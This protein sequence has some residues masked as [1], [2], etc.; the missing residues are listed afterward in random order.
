MTRTPA[1]VAALAVVWLLA[2]VPA[3][4]GYRVV[5]ENGEETLVSAGRLK[6]IGRQGAAR[7]GQD[8]HA[9]VLD[10]NRARLWIADTTKRSYWEGSVEEFCA[11]MHQAMTAAFGRLGDQMQQQMAEL[12]QQIAE[13]P[14]DE[15]AQTRQMRTMMEQMAKTAPPA[16]PAAGPPVPRVRRVTVARTGDTATIA[17]V[18]T[19][20]FR[21]RADGKRY[22][23]VWISEDPGLARELNLERAPDTFGRMFAC[24]FQG[25][26]TA[27]DGRR[28]EGTAQYRRLFGQ[29]WP[30]K[31]VSYQEDG[32]AA[33]GKTTTLVGTLERRDFAETEFRPPAGFRRASFPEVV[34]T[35]ER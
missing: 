10:V 11:G 28:V 16:A 18:P 35:E 5:D 21:V 23:D 13:L 27:P 7:G 25:V 3:R 30:L 12:Q 17:G 14:K 31:I 19:R 26:E 24:L 2:A 4:A 20:K 34:G 6:M 9:M 32:G 1:L 33:D 29:G 15:Q 8:D 22:E